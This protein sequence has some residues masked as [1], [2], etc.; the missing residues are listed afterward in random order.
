MWRSKPCVT[1][2]ASAR[3]PTPISGA[4]PTSAGFRTSCVP[5]SKAYHDEA[6][7]ETRHGGVGAST[8]ARP[9]SGLRS[10]FPRLLVRYGIERLLYRLSRTAAR[11]R[12]VLKG[13]MLFAAWADAPL[14]ATGDLDL[15]GFGDDDVEVARM[16]FAES[17]R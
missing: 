13:A 15:L 14:R 4:T 17:V 8:P 1:A 16:T 6:A 11:D 2:Y 5:N 12:F 7:A 3:Q 9:V 10:G